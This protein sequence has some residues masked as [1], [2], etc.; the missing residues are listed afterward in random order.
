MK[1]F[2]SKKAVAIAAAAGLTLGIAGGAFAYFTT[3]GSGTGTASTGSASDLTINQD[4]IDYSAA[5]DL[6]YP[7]TTADVTFTV[8]NASPGNQ[9]LGTI[10]LASW[11]SNAPLTCDS[12]LAG[13]DDWFTMPD[14]T[15]GQ[16]FTGATNGQA[17]TNGGTISFN[18]DGNQDACQGKT[19]TFTYAGTTP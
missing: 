12:S 10:S 4:T 17:V 16:N 8:D 15:V 18:D 1:L 2:K 11:T 7:G 3:T 6:F 19:I 14:V 5:D 13:Q 9:Y